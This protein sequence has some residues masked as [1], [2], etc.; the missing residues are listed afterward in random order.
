MKGLLKISILIFFISYF[1]KSYPQVDPTIP[2]PQRN[3]QN[4]LTNP[5]INDNPF[6]EQ[7]APKSTLPK[8][9]PAGQPPPPA[10]KTE[11]LQEKIEKEEEETKEE[12]D[13][14]EKEEKKEEKSDKNQSKEESS[15]DK[16][17]GL[18]GPFRIGPMVGFGILMGPNI[19]LESKI[20]RYIGFSASYGAYNNFNLFQYAKLKS[21]LNSQSNDF[22]FDTLTLSYTQFEGKFSIYPFG[23][24]FFIGAAYG[25]RNINLNS[26]GNINITI[27]NYP[28]RL[29]TPFTESIAISST[30][31]TPQIGWLATWGGS[32]GWFA[33]GTELGVQLTIQSSV[34]TSTSFTDPTVQSLIPLVVQSPEYTSLN[35]Q[36][37]TSITNSLK[38]YPLPY[39]N[40]LKIGWIF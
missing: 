19:S 27:Q 8:S 6:I 2:L 11:Q 28:T 24:N 16:E 10:Q 5:I 29:S 1:S 31:W 38:S 37:S 26:T 35:N 12:E 18:F 36:L 3:L 4:N 21:T 23:G 20:F 9:N 7:K 30:Y 40:I 22:Q 39:W 32:F 14:E 17:N 13:K 25:K 15:N 34:A 33:I